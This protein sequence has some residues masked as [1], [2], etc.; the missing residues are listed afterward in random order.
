MFIICN[1][2]TN[3]NK[4]R[5]DFILGGTAYFQNRK[6]ILKVYRYYIA[7]FYKNRTVIVL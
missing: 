1:Y 5:K 6:F 4:E 7:N 3:T 2:L